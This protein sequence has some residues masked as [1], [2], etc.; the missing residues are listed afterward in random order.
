MSQSF[1]IKKGATLAIPPGTRNFGAP[2]S[3]TPLTYESEREIL[4]Y[5]AAADSIQAIFM[6]GLVRDNGLESPFNR[7][8]F[9]GARRTLD[10]ELAGVALVGHATLIE[11]TDDTVMEAFA[12]LAKANPNTHVHLGEEERIMLFW[13]HYRRGGQRVRLICRELLFE[14]RE[15][16]EVKEE[17]KGLRLATLDDLPFVMPVQACMAFEESGINPMERDSVG[18]RLRCAR[19]IE[20][21]RVFVLIENN[22]LL[23]KAD[24]LAD[25]TRA[26][27]LEGIY[28]SPSVRNQEYGSR[29]LS[30][31]ARTLLSRTGSIKL[32]V[33][34]QNRKAH[35]F[36]RRTGFKFGG[37]YDTIFLQSGHEAKG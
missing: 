1:E 22:R 26:A 14:L 5:L 23:F 33:N 19:R 7:G 30:Q 4:A 10:G 2:P 12:R 35:D 15:P 17:V 24:I 29:C 31:V 25:T 16:L 13:Q 36:Y 3:I 37:Y 20:Q 11:T 21:G 6:T 9:Y 18:F 32:L 34:E 27:Y 28:T 8:T